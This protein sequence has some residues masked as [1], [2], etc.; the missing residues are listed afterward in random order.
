MFSLSFAE[1]P[2]A[3][4]LVIAILLGCALVTIVPRLWF[5]LEGV[6]K[7]I[8]NVNLPGFVTR[9]RTAPGA[10]LPETGEAVAVAIPS[11]AQESN[12]AMFHSAAN[13]DTLPSPLTKAEFFG[14]HTTTPPPRPAKNPKRYPRNKKSLS[15]AHT[16]S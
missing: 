6:S 13:H 3:V 5:S 14:L 8:W 1:L 15:P 11:A 4:Y 7:S 9:L 16:T 10:T 12:T 2:E